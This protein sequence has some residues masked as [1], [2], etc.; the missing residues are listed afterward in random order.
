M[1]AP[2]SLNLTSG[3]ALFKT[4]YAKVTDNM[5]NSANIM[6][7]RVKK[8]HNFTGDQML[9]SVPLSMGG[10]VGSG[11]LP[12]ANV[13]SRAKALL[14]AKK[15]Y[16]VALI[17]RESIKAALSDEG[18]FVRLT[19]QS[20]Q[21]TVE[22]YN[23]NVSRILFG[24]GD[25]SLGTIAAGGVAGLNPYVLTILDVD[26]IANTTS[27]MFKEAN[28]EE[29]DYINIGASTDLFS[30]DSIDV[31]T[32]AITVTRQ[33]GA[34][35]PLPGDVCYMQGSKDNDPQGFRSTIDK[36]AGSLYNIAIQRRWESEK[37]DAAAGA[38]SED[39]MNEVMLNIEKKFGKVPNLIMASYTQFRKLLVLISS[40]KRYPVSPRDKKL[41][42][43]ISFNG[44]EFMSTMGPVPIFSERFVEA[45]RIYFLNDNFIEVHHRPDFG[46]F[47]DDGTVFLRKADSD[48]YEARY[49]GYYENLIIPT[50]HGVL[51]NLA[52]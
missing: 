34:G 30:I 23:R 28:W 43:K 47:D 44:L 2:V 27:E 24:Y 21:D 11:T 7:A 20:V 19:K 49:G 22:S 15:V 9:H 12:K 41:I 32:K 14:T 18:A 4:K 29:G 6:A 37:K 42:G 25:G 31:A 33:T 26:A 16:G 10:S 13:K 51:H 1:A 40:E 3:S 46:W 50:A 17:D 5:Y 36:S 35:A 38:V 48:E 39:L 52:V 8:K 45:D